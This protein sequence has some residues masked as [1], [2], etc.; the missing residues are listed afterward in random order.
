MEEEK[1]KL[2]RQHGKHSKLCSWDGVS[3]QVTQIKGD[4][5]A[6]DEIDA[7]RSNTF[8]QRGRY[9]IE[10]MDEHKF[11]KSGIKWSKCTKYTNPSCACGKPVLNGTA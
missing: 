1:K 4:C 5:R 3:S 11:C 6:C 8:K 9:G 7:V 2:W 10:R